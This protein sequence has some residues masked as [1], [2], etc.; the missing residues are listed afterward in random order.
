MP[1]GSAEKSWTVIRSPFR[2][3]VWSAPVVTAEAS[4]CGFGEGAGAAFALGRLAGAA[5]AAAAVVVVVGV[6]VA[7]GAAEVDADGSTLSITTS[8]S[9]EL[10]LSPELPLSLLSPDEL[11]SELS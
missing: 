1:G 5:G 7:A 8:A 3:R 10:L 4:V 2:E 11:L 9:E 6:G